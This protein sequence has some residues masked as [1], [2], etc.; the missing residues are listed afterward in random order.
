MSQDFSVSPPREGRGA[1]GTGGGARSVGASLGPSGETLD[2]GGFVE[3][4]SVC[5][6]SLSPPSLTW[7]VVNK[8]LVKGF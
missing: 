4:T 8:E 6:C 3:K 2:A 5:P 7:V 1:Q